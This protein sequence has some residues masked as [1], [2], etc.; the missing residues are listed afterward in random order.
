MHFTVTNKFF[1]GH[2]IQKLKRNILNNQRQPA[3]NYSI[4]AKK[5]KKKTIKM[6]HLQV[7]K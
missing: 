3:P 2:V 7:L 4:I 6:Q 5:N 1:F